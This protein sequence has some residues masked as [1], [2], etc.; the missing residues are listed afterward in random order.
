MWNASKNKEMTQEQTEAQ[1][2]KVYASEEFGISFEYP[3]KYFLEEKSLGNGERIHHTIILTED[4]EE[5]RMVREG[6]APGREGPIA[7]TIDIFQNDVHYLRAEDWVKNNNSSNWKLPPDED[8]SESEISGLPAVTYPWSGLYE[9]RSVVAL[10]ED[11]IYMFS[12]THMSPQDFTVSD[13]DSLLRTVEIT[14][15]ID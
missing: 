6:Q 15:S 5:N 1:N 14:P 2:T 12:E 10:T 3:D 13:F 9:G 8:M 4:T 11:F 7:I